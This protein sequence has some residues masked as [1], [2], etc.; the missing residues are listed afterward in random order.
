M[1]VMSTKIP[2]ATVMAMTS[3]VM[4]KELVVVGGREGVTDT[5]VE[6]DP[7]NL[8]EEWLCNSLQVNSMLELTE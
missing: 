4:K 1:V 6:N 2:A 3:S 5:L 7:A 8:G